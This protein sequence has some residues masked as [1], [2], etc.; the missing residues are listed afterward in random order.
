MPASVQTSRLERTR[1]AEF[2][3]RIPTARASSERAPLALSSVVAA[4]PCAWLPAALPVCLLVFDNGL[5]PPRA[6]FGAVPATTGGRAASPDPE[7]RD[8]L[9]RRP[10]SGQPTGIGSAT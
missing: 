4:R 10:R 5:Y 9:R 2:A 6:S 3:A 8:E 1:T 7:V